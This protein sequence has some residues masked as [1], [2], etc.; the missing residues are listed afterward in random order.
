MTN[1][2]DPAGTTEWFQGRTN[3]FGA[4]A[5]AMTS[6]IAANYANTEGVGDISNWL[7]TPAVD[8]VDGDILA[9]WTRTGSGSAWNDRLEVRSSTGTM[10]LPADVNDVGSFTTLHMMIN[11]GYDLSY[12]ESWTRYAVTVSGVGST[13]VPTRFAFRYNVLEGGPDGTN[14]NFIGIDAVFIGDPADEDAVTE[15]FELCTPALD[16]TD[17]DLITNVTFQEIGNTTACGADGYSDFTGMVAQVY[18]GQSYPISVTVGDGWSNES[19][20][21]WVDRNGNDSFEEDEFTYIGTG[22]GS[23]VTGT[24]AIPAGT[25]DGNYRMRVRVAAVGASGATYDLACDD[26]QGYGETEDY[27]VQ[28]GL[29]AGIAAS[30]SVEL[31][32]WPN[33]MNNVLYIRTSTPVADVAVFSVLG[34]QVM[35]VGNLTT[36]Q[37]DVSGLDAGT[38]VLR[39]TMPDGATS[40]FRATKE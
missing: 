14:S 8:V 21:V 3:V 11:D 24:V 20:S 28:V 26:G 2:S 7:I 38:Y 27:T 5:G 37:L 33:P 17:G 25:S 22:S 6:Y 31:A 10:T 40:T 30:R 12:P 34:Q 18:A 36:G 9:F 35:H 13:P 15:P 29:G 16:C 32:H 19:V 1:Q 4:Y 23:V 39:I